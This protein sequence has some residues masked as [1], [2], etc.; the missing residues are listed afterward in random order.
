MT[1]AIKYI[2]S[3][4]VSESIRRLMSVSKGG[5]T[6][7]SSVLVLCSGEG[8]EGS[9]LCD[10]GFS[11]V[12]VSDIDENAVKAALSRDHRLKGVTLNADRPAVEIDSYDVSLVQDGLHHL[13]SPV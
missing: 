10:L 3:W 13:T 8:L 11:N 2:V 12:T 7:D 6:Y 4:R 9:I 1:P 5:I